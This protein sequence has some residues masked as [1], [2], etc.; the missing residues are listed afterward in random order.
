MEPKYM[1]C[2]YIILILILISLIYKIEKTI[3]NKNK[4]EIPTKK[5]LILGAIKNLNWSELEPFFV[6][7]KKANFKS[8]DCVIFY[9]NLTNITIQNIQSYGVKTIKMAEKYNKMKINNVRYKLYDDYLNNK[10]NKY[11]I[12]LHVDIRDT[13]FIKDFFEMYKNNTKSF[14]GVTLE[15]GTITHQINRVWMKHQYGVKIYEKLKDE[16]IICSGTIWGTPDKFLELAR[17]IWEEINLI[18]PFDVEVHDQTATNYIIYYKKKF[19]DSI[20]KYSNVY[21]PVMTIGISDKSKLKYDSEGNLLTY[22]GSQ[23]TI[24]HQYDR[25]S[26]TEIKEMVK[27]QYNSTTIKEKPI[28]KRKGINFY[29]LFILSVI[30]VTLIINIIVT[31]VYLSII[32]RKNSNH[33]TENFSFEKVSIIKYISEKNQ[34][35]YSKITDSEENI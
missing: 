5:N 8:C 7:L 15:D 16:R 26:M 33:K 19:Q 3:K 23:P 13:L 29:I 6:S 17:S 12:I 22:N 34:I 31:K 35:K 24:I 25:L 18:S 10:T 11:N 21:G 28:I 20:I 2:F 4:K 30:I 27:K 9:N 14:I 32:N 1:V